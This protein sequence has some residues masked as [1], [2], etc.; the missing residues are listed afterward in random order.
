MRLVLA[1]KKQISAEAL[2]TAPAKAFAPH[3]IGRTRTSESDRNVKNS[4]R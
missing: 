1:E 2:H 3:H 4:F